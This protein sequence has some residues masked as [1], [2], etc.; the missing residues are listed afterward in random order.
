M[1]FQKH[2]NTYQQMAAEFFKFIVQ[3]KLSFQVKNCFK[4]AT[5]FVILNKW[6][7]SIY[8]EHINYK[9]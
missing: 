4:T 2:H 1:S 7:K 6:L 3:L 9:D 8:D 5:L